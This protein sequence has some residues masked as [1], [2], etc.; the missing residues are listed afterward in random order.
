M[1]FCLDDEDLAEISLE[2]ASVSNLLDDLL[3]GLWGIQQDSL[4]QLLFWN[5][6]LMLK[7]EQQRVPPS[8]GVEYLKNSKVQTDKTKI[9]MKMP[10]PI[11]K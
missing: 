9:M 5:R 1:E 11:E 7:H 6:V 8:D 2:L 4:W 3:P 10:I